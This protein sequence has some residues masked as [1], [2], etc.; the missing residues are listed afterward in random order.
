MFALF[1]PFPSLSTLPPPKK[2]KEEKSLPGK[3]GVTVPSIPPLKKDRGERE[4]KGNFF[5]ARFSV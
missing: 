5:F 2:R 1:C 4:R 3:E